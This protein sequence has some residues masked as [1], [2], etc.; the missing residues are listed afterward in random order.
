MLWPSFQPRLWQQSMDLLVPAWMSPS[1][2]DSKSLSDLL[3]LRTYLIIST[4]SEISGIYAEEL[5]MLA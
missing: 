3:F 2:L 1:V 5:A 4:G